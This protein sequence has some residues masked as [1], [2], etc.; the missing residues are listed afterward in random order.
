MTAP[1]DALTRAKEAGGIIAGHGPVAVRY[2][3]EAVY[4]GADLALDQAMRL[5][6]DLATLL[7][8]TSDRSEG[9]RAFA[10]KRTPEFRGE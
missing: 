1:G 7:H 9:L 2:L 8:S 5:E 6:V 4:K 3:K 10:D